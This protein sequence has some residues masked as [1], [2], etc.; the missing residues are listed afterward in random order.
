MLGCLDM[1]KVVRRRVEKRRRLGGSIDGWV[2]RGKKGVGASASRRRRA[3][4]KE[5]GDV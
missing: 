2:V 3:R 5:P 1:A 4:K